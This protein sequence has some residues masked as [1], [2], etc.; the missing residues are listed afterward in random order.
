MKRYGMFLI[1]TLETHGVRVINTTPALIPPQ[2]PRKPGQIKESLSV[3]AK[4]AYLAG[5][6]HGVVGLNPQLICVVLPGR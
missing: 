3:A 5:R 4:Q 1:E 2:D 6:K